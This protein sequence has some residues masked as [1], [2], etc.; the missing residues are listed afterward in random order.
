MK[1]FVFLVAAHVVKSNYMNHTGF[2]MRIAMEGLVFLKN[3]SLEIF[4]FLIIIC[5]VFIGQGLLIAMES[6]WNMITMSGL[7]MVGA[8]MDGA[9]H[10]TVRH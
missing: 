6:V 1:A 4:V 7:E 2:V 5:Q 3:L 10:L 8:M 9:I